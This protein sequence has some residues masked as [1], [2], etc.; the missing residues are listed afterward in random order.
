MLALLLLM[1]ALF[2]RLPSYLRGRELEDQLAHVLVLYSAGLAEAANQ[3]D[4]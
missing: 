1:A 4:A 2:A 3:F